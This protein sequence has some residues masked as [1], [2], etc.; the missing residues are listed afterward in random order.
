[1]PAE[2]WYSRVKQEGWEAIPVTVHER[3]ESFNE[4]KNY[5]EEVKDL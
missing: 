4:M 2:I 5:V 1:M 3:Q